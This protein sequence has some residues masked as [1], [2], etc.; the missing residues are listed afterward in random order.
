MGRRPRVSFRCSPIDAAD[1]IAFRYAQ[2]L[3]RIQ[4]IQN[5]GANS[6]H[7]RRVTHGQFILATFLHTLQAT[8]SNP[9]LIRS[10]QC[11]ILSVW[12][13][14]TQAGFTPASQSDL[15]SPHVHRM[16]RRSCLPTCHVIVEW[17]N[18]VRVSAPIAFQVPILDVTFGLSNSPRDRRKASREQETG[19]REEVVQTG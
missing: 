3:G 6:I 10:L 1:G 11:S 14:L 19:F 8:L 17:Q 7:C 12:L 13:T 5:F 4:Q 2:A 9:V 18:Q 15:A 16:V